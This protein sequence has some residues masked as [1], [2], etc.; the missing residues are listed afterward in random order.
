MIL[1]GKAK[2]GEIRDLIQNNET[3]ED[4]NFKMLTASYIHLLHQ[5][6]LLQLV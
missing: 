4:D 5:Q 1:K 2:G 3:Y 6:L